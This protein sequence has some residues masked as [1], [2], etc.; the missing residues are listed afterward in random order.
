MTASTAHARRHTVHTRETAAR[1]P[2]RHR[3]RATAPPLIRASAILE[4]VFEHRLRPAIQDLALV[5]GRAR[6][7][8]RGKTSSSLVDVDLTSGQETRR[9]DRLPRIGKAW[10]AADGSGLGIRRTAAIG[11]GETALIFIDA[12]GRVIH[13]TSVPDATSEVAAGP[14]RWYAGCRDGALFAFTRDGR[15]GWVWEI[16][17][18][19]HDITDRYARPCPYYV[20]AHPSGVVVSSFANIYA[21][22]AEG[23]TRWHAALPDAPPVAWPIGETDCVARDVAYARLGLPPNAG[24]RSIKTAFKRQ[25]VASHPD[26]HPNDPDAPSRFVEVRQAYECLRHGDGS[27]PGDPRS[28]P[29][30]VFAGCDPTVT[31]LATG[32]EDTVIAGSSDGRVYHVDATGRLEEAQ[33][34]G[35]HLVRAAR[36]PDGILGAV[37]CG[38]AL[39]FATDDHVVH[40]ASRIREPRRMTMCGEDLVLWNGN[41][42][43]LIDT[44][45][46]VRWSAAFSKRLTHVA[47]Q[48]DR[49]VCAA[50]ACTV[51]R[52]A[53]ERER[54]ADHRVA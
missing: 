43:E 45:G 10:F 42:I 54:L 6:C 29:T 50:G 26:R 4:R 35:D 49:L 38:H 52:R 12:G 53:G 48:G 15:P 41:E 24:D 3:T 14:D 1:H 31:F 19:Q 34:F 21:I 17:G 8:L 46:H 23:R 9:I 47:A 36:R 28:M 20:M 11:R 5:K 25:A 37:S 30:I 32:P 44:S 13:E 39:R 7:L 51:F 16:P 27:R 40:S 2:L 18:S 33:V 22:D